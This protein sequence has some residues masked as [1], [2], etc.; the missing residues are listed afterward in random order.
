MRARFSLSGRMAIL[1]AGILAGAAAIAAGV[2]RLD[3]DLAAWQVFLLVLLLTLPPALWAL[4]RFLRPVRDLLAALSDGIESFRDRDFSVRL[5]ADRTDEVGQ[6]A[7]AYNQAADLL[8]DERH[9]LRQRELLLETALAESPLAIVL[10]GP[11]GRVVYSNREARRLFVGGQPLEGELFDERLAAG[12]AELGRMLAEGSDGLFAVETGGEPETYHLSQR[13]FQLDRRSHRLILLRRITGELGRQEAAIWKKVIRVI[14]HELNNSLAPISSLV[15][16]AELVAADPRHAH[17][18]VEIYSTIRD[19]IDHLVGFLEGYARFARLPAPRKRRVAWSE[20][21]G[22]VNDLYAFEVE[23]ELPAEPA[24]VDPGQID[25]VL[26]NLIKNAREA[27]ADGPPPR[28]RVS[29]TP[30]RGFVL[31][32]RDQGPGMTREVLESALLPFYSTKRSGGGLGLALCREIVEAHGGRLSLRSRL[33]TGTVVAC[34][35]PAAP[36]SA[37]GE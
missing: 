16:S 31:Q 2:T 15:H 35:L 18:S 19:R 37:A 7:A 9:H 21:L 10:V 33:G 8:R 4:D 29:A 23:G 1:V 34:W 11:T 26:I 20:L 36:R 13:H 32:V 3:L 22:E 12:P 17:R 27:S 14:S 28:V 30:D 25:Q 6:L 5:A 24:F